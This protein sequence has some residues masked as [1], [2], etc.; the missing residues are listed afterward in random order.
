MTKPITVADIGEFGLLAE[1]NALLQCKDNSVLLPAGDDCTALRWPP[2]P[3]VAS[4]DA[5]VEGVHF[6][7][8]WTEPEDLAW[9]AL[10]SAVSDLAAKG[11]EPV[12]ALVTLGLVADMQVDWVLRMYQFWVSLDEPWSC[13]I[14]GGD[15][16]RSPVF[17]VDV[18]VLGRPPFNTL[19]RNNTAQAGDEILVTGTLGDARGGLDL[20]QAGAVVSPGSVEERLVRRFLRPVARVAE[21]RQLLVGGVIPTAMTDISDGLGRTL[22]NLSQASGVGAHVRGRDLPLS[23]ALCQLKGEAAASF[24]WRGGEDYE[25]LLTI[26]KE[27]LDIALEVARKVAVSLTRIGEMTGPRNEVSVEGLPNV[28]EESGYD[29]F[30]S[31]HLDRPDH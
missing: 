12:A 18:F 13:P 22:R 20:L 27:N 29:H 21:M 15:V 19:I 5:M 25:L 6:G 30:A 26:P 3:V 17:F 1:I 23:D 8:Q 31:G 28:E 10:A 24:A 14:L 4:S 9:K 16:V 11:A 2:G 7:L